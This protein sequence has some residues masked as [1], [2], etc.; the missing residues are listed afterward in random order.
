SRAREPGPAL[1]HTAAQVEHRDADQARVANAT[2]EAHAA[3]RGIRRGRVDAAA[4]EPGF[5][6]DARRVV[7]DDDVAAIRDLVVVAAE[8]EV[9]G[10]RGNAGDAVVAGRVGGAGVA[11]VLAGRLAHEHADA[12]DGRG[13]QLVRDGAA[14]GAGSERGR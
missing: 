5:D 1:H 4:Q 14:H 13:G 12:F 7:G 6:V 2:R 11:G 8:L 9:V 3:A 10:A